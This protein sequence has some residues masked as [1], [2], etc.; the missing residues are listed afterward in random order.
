MDL[1]TKTNVLFRMDGR[2]LMGLLIK[3]CRILL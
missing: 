1:R 2:Q 3:I